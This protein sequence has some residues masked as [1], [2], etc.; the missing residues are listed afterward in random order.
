MHIS[1]SLRSFVSSLR[2]VLWLWGMGMLIFLVILTWPDLISN[3]TC[4]FLHLQILRISN[5]SCFWIWLEPVLHMVSL[6]RLCSI[7]EMALQGCGIFLCGMHHFISYLISVFR[8]HLKTDIKQR[9]FDNHA[10]S[11]SNC[12][13]SEK[14]AT[15]HQ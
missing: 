7:H 8:L 1:F 9:R 15:N 3:L 6:Y 10:L 4:S 13:S 12:K 11:Y 5:W 2:P 14:K